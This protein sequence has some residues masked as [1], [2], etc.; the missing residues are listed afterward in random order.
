MR[1]EK[2]VDGK[3]GEDI[4]GAGDDCVSIYTYMIYIRLKL[5]LR[6]L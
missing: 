3:G 1:E 4:D 2:K 5:H 6:S